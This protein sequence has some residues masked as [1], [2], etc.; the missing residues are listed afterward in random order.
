MKVCLRSSVFVL[1][2]FISAGVFAQ[3]TT[4]YIVSG[5]TN[6]VGQQS[7]PYVIYISI[8]GLGNDFADKF[9]AEFLKKKREEGVQA[10]SMKPSFPSLTFP[11]HYTLATGLYPAHHGLVGN[12]FRAGKNAEFSYST[13]DKKAVSNPGFYG[14]VPIWVLAEKH[15]MLSAA[16]YWVGS[17]AP[18]DSTFASY[19]YKYN[20]A[21]SVDRRIE[22][23]KEWLQ[24][25][26]ER[27]PH[28]IMFYMPE[29]DH[30]IHGH[31]VESDSTR[32]AIQLV[33]YT[34]KR[35][36]EM[37]DSLGLP[38]NYILVS[39][40]GMA[41]VDTKNPILIPTALDTSKF[42]MSYNSTFI[43][44]YAKD[45]KDVKKTY[46]NLKK[47]A[48]NYSVYLKTNTPARW[49]YR[50]KDDCY[51]R[52]GD[53]ILVAD[54]GKAFNFFNR[55]TLPGEHGYD[56]DAESMQATFYAW[57]PAFKE[58]YRIPSFENIHVYPVVAHL[59]G[60]PLICEVDGKLEVLKDI[61][62]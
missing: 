43:Q 31:G 35:M 46:K 51:N 48:V 15:R 20:E 49:H 21:I 37:T 10:A 56:N 33:D 32:A 26:E 45:K 53:I 9:N 52:L 54:E 22:I 59:L 39:D 13:R 11:N 24:L 57:G 8:D 34:I 19:Y 36:N 47:E 40:H 6:S 14:G 58:K 25:P 61:L 50:S 44:L 3:D 4:Q 38:V 2:Y 17:E 5:R 23:V 12:S 27:R 41:D 60:L 7:K 30:Q 18:V 62:R 42:K 1:V 29:V 55:P 16:F 28:L